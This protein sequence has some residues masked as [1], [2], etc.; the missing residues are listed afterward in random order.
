MNYFCPLLQ[1]TIF[2]RLHSSKCFMYYC[3]L[4][5]RKTRASEYYKRASLC[6]NCHCLMLPDIRNFLTSCSIYLWSSFA[7]HIHEALG[8]KVFNHGVILQVVD[9]FCG[10]YGCFIALLNFLLWYHTA[11]KVH[12]P[13]VEENCLSYWKDW[14]FHSET[15]TFYTFLGCCMDHW[16]NF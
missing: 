3:Y 10:L 6:L 1:W 13:W 12:F 5:E 8:Y 11:I 15:V 9:I 16:I 4:T 2:R 14:P 7:V